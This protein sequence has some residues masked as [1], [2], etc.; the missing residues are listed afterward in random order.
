VFIGKTDVDPDML[1]ISR[2]VTDAEGEDYE[3]DRV[4]DD[5]SK[6]DAES[7]IR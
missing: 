1:S 2:G 5:G 3:D 7:V 4:S 6:W